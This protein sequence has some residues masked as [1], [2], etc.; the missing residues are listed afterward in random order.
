M[1]ELQHAFQPQGF[2]VRELFADVCQRPAGDATDPYDF[3]LDYGR[4]TLD[5]RN[6]FQLT[7]SVI[8]A[9]RH[10]L[11]AVHHPAVGLAL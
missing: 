7:G 1:V 4:S 5:R 6:N 11:G 9:K 3:L 2:A 8:G 10:S